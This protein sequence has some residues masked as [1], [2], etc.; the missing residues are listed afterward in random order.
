M[1]ISNYRSRVRDLFQKPKLVR[2][3]MQTLVVV[4]ANVQ[5]RELSESWDGRANGWLYEI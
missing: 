5:C 1:D 4:C 3:R 2:S